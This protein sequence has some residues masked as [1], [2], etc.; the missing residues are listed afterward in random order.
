MGVFK[1]RN[2]GS[3]TIVLVA[4]VASLIV[5]VSNFEAATGRETYDKLKLFSEV[6][7]LVESSY[8]DEVDSGKLVQGA[9]RGMLKELDPHTAYMTE[10]MFNEMQV[11]TK[12]EFGGLGITI[13]LKTDVLTVIS[14]IEDTPAWRAGIKAGDR[15]LKVDGESTKDMSVE[16]AVKKMRGVPGTPITIS[17]MRDE[18]KEPKDFTI[19]RDVIKLKS[20]KSR[21]IDN[22]VGYLRVTQFQ[23]RTDTDLE[24][25]LAALWTQNPSLKG[26]ILDLR[27]NPGGLL[28]QA[29]QV[30]GSFLEKGKL[31][32]YTKGRKANNNVEYKVRGN[33]GRTA[34]P[35]VVLVNHGSASASEIVAGALQDWGRAVILGVDTFGKG[36]VQTV[37]PLEDGFGLRLT[38]AKYYTP[39]GRSIQN[40][41]IKPDIIVPTATIQIKK[42]V[43]GHVAK[44]KDLEGH[45]ANETEP[46]LPGAL[47]PATPSTPAGAGEEDPEPEALEAQSDEEDFQLQRALDLLK[48]WDIFHKNQGATT[49]KAD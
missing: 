29:V 12:G 38:T 40:T 36:S 4:L 30:S 26:V 8:V 33:G 41:G 5:G 27:N 34:F 48:T 9:I 16:N 37:I 46:S 6:L 28:D 18:F 22:A 43:E 14:P 7:S 42:A 47:P 11:D 21:V 3:G 35:M 39:K 10:D 20:V 13:G 23:E 24:Q 2:L 17:I 49:A 32:V 45:L 15:I 44:E 25:A 31:V 1:Q 19:V